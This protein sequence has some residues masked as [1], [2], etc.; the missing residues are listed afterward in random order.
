[1]QNFPPF[2]PLSRGERYIAFLV[3]PLVAVVLCTAAYALL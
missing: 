1:M 3:T 2:E